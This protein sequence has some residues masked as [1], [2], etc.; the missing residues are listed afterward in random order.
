LTDATVTT[1]D[2]PQRQTAL[3]EGDLLCVSCDYN[4]RGVSMSATC[5]ECGADVTP[6]IN[7]RW[8]SHAYPSRVR[9]I[10]A[11]LISLAVSLGLVAI[12]I[13]V[14]FLMLVLLLVF[15]A[16]L[17]GPDESHIGIIEIVNGYL[18]KLVLFEHGA[19]MI[20]AILLTPPSPWRIIRPGRSPQRAWLV[21]AVLLDVLTISAAT[22]ESL[23]VILPLAFVTR[24][25]V[26]QRLGLVLACHARNIASVPQLIHTRRV[27]PGLLIGL[28]LMAL[29]AIWSMVWSILKSSGLGYAILPSS[30][31]GIVQTICSFSIVVGFGMTYACTVWAMAYC[32]LFI[33]RFNRWAATA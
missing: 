2:P 33:R 8:L 15:S 29:P 27:F 21:P 4:L 5:P 14:L 18:S 16:S 31:P 12:G 30:Q 13:P 23:D 28:T 6:S 20:A 26:V 11:G 24:W 10:R 3:I 9:R 32:F 22:V 19:W 25:L 17:A 7:A 1:P